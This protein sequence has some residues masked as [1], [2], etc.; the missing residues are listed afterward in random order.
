MELHVLPRGEVTLASAAEIGNI[1]E[2]FH[3]GRREHA[4]GNFGAHHLN[5]RL[6][7]SIASE[8][9]AVRAK[10]VISDTAGCVFGGFL[11]KGL[12]FGPDGLIVLLVEFV[13][14]VRN[15]SIEVGQNLNLRILYRE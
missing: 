6:A 10:I 12:D 3:L 9:K 13:A 1:R 8:T 4:A 11:A 7:L 15:G 14:S 5:A 2:P